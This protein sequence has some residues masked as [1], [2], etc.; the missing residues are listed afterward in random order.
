[1]SQEG[2]LR[3]RMYHLQKYESIQKEEEKA[4]KAD[5]ENPEL[6]SKMLTSKGVSTTDLAKFYM[7]VKERRKDSCAN[8]I[9]QYLWL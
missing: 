9:L 2:Y 5:R 7:T 4:T 1:M 8:T 6:P 3:G